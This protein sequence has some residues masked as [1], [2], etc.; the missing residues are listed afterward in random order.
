MRAWFWTLLVF[1]AAVILASVLKDH[2][3]N[4]LIL[5]QPWRIELSL[6]FAVLLL[7]A[8]F[9]VLHIFLR[10]L[11]WL[12]GSPT[13]FRSWRGLKAQK[14]DQN[15]LESAWINVL[16]GRYELA[17]KDLSRLLGKTRSRTSRVVAGLA[18]TRAAHR[19]GDKLKRDQI[20]ADVTVNAQHDHRL[21]E[22]VAVVTAEIL[23][24][25]NRAAEAIVLLQPLQDASSRY[26]HATKLLLR[27]HKQ[28]GN[29]ERV[30][31]LTRLLLRRGVIDQV[32]ARNL[33]EWSASSGLQAADETKFKALWSD[34]RHD[35]KTLPS[36]AMAAAEVHTKAQRYDEAAKILEASLNNNMYPQLLG[37]YSQ[38]PADKVKHRLNKAEQWLKQYPQNPDLLALLGLLCITSE[39]WGQAERYLLES[40]NIRSDMRI[41]ALL[42]NLYDGLD[43]P[44]DAAKHWRLSATVVQNLPGFEVV[45]LLPAADTSSD[46]TLIEVDV[47][48]S[49][50]K[51]ILSESGTVITPEAAS[52]ADV[53]SKELN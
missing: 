19:L 11:S 5:V 46:P 48:Q 22:A 6:T 15:L 2:S 21:K 1:A 43:R 50:A 27:A 18:A 40:M 3:G 32:N 42:G 20:L 52:A 47:A 10:F 16:E 13:R 30:Y 8:I 14:R 38:C 9:F 12:G 36:V 39:L 33:I 7:L 28:M 4:V 45:R 53:V 44:E 23:I 49:P 41:H 35:E 51:Q 17:D 29:Y 31:E 24:D 37:L 26:F 25:D 34:L